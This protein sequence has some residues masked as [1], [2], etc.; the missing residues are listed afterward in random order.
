MRS[1]VNRRKK[2]ARF[3]SHD[4]EPI[5]RARDI[6][7]MTHNFTQIS[8]VHEFGH[9]IK[10]SHPGGISNASAAYLADP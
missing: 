6:N 10:L 1:G 4:I 7:N 8:V 2:I 5:N 3:D 9:M